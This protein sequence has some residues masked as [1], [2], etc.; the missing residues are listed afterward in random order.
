MFYFGL[1]SNSNPILDGLRSLC[2]ILKDIGLKIKQPSLGFTPAGALLASP[3]KVIGLDAV[4][5]QACQC[6]KME[7]AVSNLYTRQQHVLE[8]TLVPAISRSNYTVVVLKLD[9][10]DL[11]YHYVV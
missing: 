9:A 6:Q 7:I 11:F 4:F 3:F 2:Y 8:S 1:G 10:V 5:T